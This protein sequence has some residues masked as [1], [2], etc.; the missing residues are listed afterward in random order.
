MDEDFDLCISET[1]LPFPYSDHCSTGP[2]SLYDF[3]Q[4]DE[5]S[6]EDEDEDA[7]DRDPGEDGEGASR[8]TL[9]KEVLLKEEEDQDGHTE[10]WSSLRDRHERRLSNSLP[11]QLQKQ[12]NLLNNNPSDL[13]PIL[14]NDSSTSLNAPPPRLARQSF[15]FDSNGFWQDDEEEGDISTNGLTPNTVLERSEERGLLHTVTSTC[16]SVAYAVGKHWSKVTI[17]LCGK[18]GLTNQSIVQ[19]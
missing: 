12:L 16:A 8:G 17:V 6:Y 2:P 13:K 9:H 5:E 1:N 7:A 14:R 4:D 11:D 3:D 18:L 19:G 15:S 10:G